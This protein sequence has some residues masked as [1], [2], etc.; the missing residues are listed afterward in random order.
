MPSAA[1]ACALTILAAGL[2]LIDLG[3][4]SLWTDEMH[5]VSVAGIPYGPEP[6][7]WRWTN[8]LAV[9]QGPLFM[10]LLHAWSALA[11]T[12]EAALRLLPAFFAI[13]T[14]PFLLF[15]GERLLDRRAAAFAALLLAVSPFHV[16]YAQ[17]L[18][19]YSLVI[20][21]AVAATA[22][23]LGLIDWR[24]SSQAAAIGA[25]ATSAA[26]TSAGAGVRPSGGRYALYGLSLLAGLGASLIMGFM[27]VVHG[28]AIAARARALGG[29]RVA[30][31]LAVFVVVGA[32]TAPWL[33]VFGRRHDVGRAIAEPQV[34]EP[35][36]RG[37]TTMPALAI[38]YALYAFSA[39]F[40]LGPSLE[41]LHVD[42]EGAVRRHLPIVSTVALVY[43]GL[44]VAGMAVLAIKRRGTA[45][46][47]AA[48]IAIP[49]GLAA[50]MAATNV[51]VWN[52]RYV[53]VAFPAYLLCVGAGLG[54]LAARWRNIL[55][56]LAVGL[57]L[58]SVWNLHHDP[59][60]AK[61]DYRAAAAYLDR[62]LAARDALIG[63]G[64]PGPLFFYLEKR[65]AAYQVIHPHRIGDGGELRRR[66][67]AASAG[68]PRVWIFRARTTQSD[69]GN[70]VGEI[71]K[72][73]RR[74]GVR[75]T[76]HG[77][78]IERYDAPADT[79]AAISQTYGQEHRHLLNC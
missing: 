71:L 75:A 67:S 36:M 17:E 9:T 50:W 2:R 53:A 62:A 42:G 41:E 39:G 56:A 1:L 70:Q 23:L 28:L 79:A 27:L 64:A 44:A 6:T 78:E 37:A 13:A 26:T 66:L 54:A 76:F 4:D 5:T 25:G 19:G 69:P 20:L 46:L 48:W 38:P 30:A 47:L 61:E 57:A 3:R 33:G 31:L 60:Y 29:R 52:P 34:E 16:W 18:R 77:I 58:L 74:L 63:V 40:S 59:D 15:L 8:L 72:E 35:P 32:V 45:L 65:P 21:A 24:G 11:G 51:K 12:S 7:S 73:T 68:R 14:V 10:G 49:V 55:F 22:L 43:G